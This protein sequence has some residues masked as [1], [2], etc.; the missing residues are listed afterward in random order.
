MTHAAIVITK[1]RPREVAAF[2]ESLAAQ[3]RRPDEIIV[4]DASTRDETRRAVE[5]IQR[6]LPDLH[7]ATL[8]TAANIGGQ[9]NEGLDS[10]ATDIVSFFDD[11]VLLPID[12]CARV[13]ARFEADSEE[14]VCG[15]AGIPELAR[16]PAW[17]LRVFRKLFFLQTNR[18]CNRFR[19]SGI[20]DFGF[21]FDAETEV[22]FL[23]STAVS[24]RRNAVDG[25]RFDSEQLTGK[26]L[27]LATGRGF[28]EDVEFS[29]AAGRKGKLLVL[30]ALHFRHK[31]SPSSRENTFVTQALYV[32]A[33]RTVSDAHADTAARR[34]AR[35]WALCGLGLLSA[36]QTI[37]YRDAGYLRGY[38]RAM[39][40][41]LFVSGTEHKIP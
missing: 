24:F 10:A 31:E 20:P 21:R 14:G 1:D 3:V 40:T 8:R 28:A 6:S 13:L 18:G 37:W 9:K 26:A 2:L 16:E 27:G 30:P 33:M 36:F 17:P 34:V 15:L 4:V 11:D 7:I 41:G 32:F 5:D 25:I 29:H 22:E 12:Y 38:Q 19:F 39:G 23:A 35:W